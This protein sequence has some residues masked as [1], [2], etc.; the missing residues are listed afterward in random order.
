MSLPQELVKPIDEIKTP[1]NKV[2]VI[3]LFLAIIALYVNSLYDKSQTTKEAKAQARI[4]EGELNYW[5]TIARVKD[6]LY[7]DCGNK[8]YEDAKNTNYAVEKRSKLNDSIQTL[9][10]KITR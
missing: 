3:A 4:Y 1:S 9:I 6:S 10:K 7:D 8:R 5:K 2:L